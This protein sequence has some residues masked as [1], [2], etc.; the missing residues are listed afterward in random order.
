[1]GD[2][3]KALLKPSNSGPQRNY[4]K[5]SFHTGR[6]DEFKADAAAYVYPETPIGR[7]VA[8]P[9]TTEIKFKLERDVSTV[10][11]N[12]LNNFNRIFRDQGKTYRFESKADVFPTNPETA[13]QLE[14]STKFFGAPDKV[15][16]LDSKVL[17]FIEYKTPH[18]LTGKLFDLLEMYEEDI[19]Y[20]QSERIR[21]H[22]GRTDV[23]PVIEQV[24][25]YLSLNNLIYGCVTCYD[26]TYFFWRPKRGTLLI[27]H[28]VFNH[29]RSPTLLQ[30]LYYFVQLVLRDNEK[31]ILE[32]SPKDSDM[33][34]ELNFNEK[35]DIDEHITEGPSDSGSNYSTTDQRKETNV[36]GGKNKRTKYSVNGGKNKRTKYSVN[37]DSLHSGTVVGFGATGRVIRL[38]DSN[39]VAKHCDSYNNPEGFKMLKNEIAV[40]EKLST[41]NLVYVPR[42]YGEYELYGQ[43]FILLDYIPGKHCDWRKSPELTE[44]LKAV[45]RDLNSIGVVHQDLRPENVLLTRDG[46]IKLID[47]GKA[48]IQ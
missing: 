37:V 12:H 32:S 29:S 14:N 38:K 17:T 35:M 18:D 19:K 33:P 39:I 27:S 21:G 28:P 22:I 48:E 26:A 24:Y 15:L 16:T 4:S 5:T 20:Q 31:Q 25:G 6:W 36:N 10:I 3:E 45:I 23:R 40:Y 11:Q 46:D 13:T 44:K 8:L 1:M 42:Y 41:H 30:T 9:A 34:L 43:H 47:F 7:D 2:I